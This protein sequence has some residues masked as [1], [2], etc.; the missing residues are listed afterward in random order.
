ML[1]VKEISKY[2]SFKLFIESF[3]EDLSK[4]SFN[5]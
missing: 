1:F 4:V 5:F 3:I 2:A